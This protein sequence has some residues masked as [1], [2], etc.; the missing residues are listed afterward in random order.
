MLLQFSSRG[1][2]FEIIWCFCLWHHAKDLHYR[3][4]IGECFFRWRACFYEPVVLKRP[5]T[6]FELFSILGIDPDS[7]EEIFSCSGFVRREVFDKS[8]H[9]VPR[10]IS[11]TIFI[12]K[13]YLKKGKFCVGCALWQAVS[14]TQLHV[15]WLEVSGMSSFGVVQECAISWVRSAGGWDSGK[16][17]LVQE[18]RRL[19][20]ML[21]N[22]AI[23][24]AHQ[25]VM[26]SSLEHNLLPIR[27]HDIDVLFPE[28]IFVPVVLWAKPVRCRLVYMLYKNE[29]LGIARLCELFSKPSQLFC[30]RLSSF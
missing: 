4:T 3:L 12:C 9:R 10:E 21:I 8:L 19:W 26:A 1:A 24:Y 20:I 17:D 5:D 18:I 29:P 13:V 16:D 23:P 2:F 6:I 11:E 22:F 14:L 30:T 7:V 28:S 25:M 27:L 15:G